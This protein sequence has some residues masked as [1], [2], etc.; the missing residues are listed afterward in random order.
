[1]PLA[2][3]EESNGIVGGILQL[4]VF[5]D[6]SDVREHTRSRPLRVAGLVPTACQTVTR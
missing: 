3:P 2:G 1:M 4:I 5:R 6:R